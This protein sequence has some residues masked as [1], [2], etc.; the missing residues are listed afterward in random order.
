LNDRVVRIKSW[1]DF[2]QLIIEHSPQS[3]VYN[4]EQSI[5]ARHLKGLRLILP[6]VGTQYVF[7]DFASG[8][9]LK[10]T[11]ISL[12]KDGMGNLY[13]KDE[14]VK[15]FVRSETKLKDLKFHSYWTI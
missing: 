11:G 13:I 5:P 15:E 8:D 9:C 12:Q 6:V 10:K 4:I 1:E 14:D 7:L 3:I 2:K